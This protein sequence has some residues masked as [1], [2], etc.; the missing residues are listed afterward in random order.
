MSDKLI[1]EAEAKTEG[2]EPKSE[3]AEPKS[4]GAEP[5]SEG[6]EPKSEGAEPKSEGA[7]PKSE[8]AEPKRRRGHLRVAAILESAGA[9]FAQQ[10]YD[11]VTMTEVAV[12]SGTA[13]GSLYR[14]F[15]TKETLADALLKRYAERLDGA[16]AGLE[17]AARNMPL[18]AFADAL[19]EH[20]L[21]WGAQRAAALVLIE[22]RSVGGA[23]RGKLRAVL[24]D[25]L[26]EAV[27]AINPKLPADEV[28]TKAR[29]LQL[30]FKM[31]AGNAGEG[32]GV[33]SEIRALA[34][35]F[36]RERV[37]AG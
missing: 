5:K 19:V 7:E 2:A 22:A 26:A 3:G 36:L 27:A 20:A 21:A 10:G 8:G 29:V 30:I 33:L 16:L 4:E 34:R 14:F 13:I 31:A 15:P 24:H 11:A 25:R 17:R 35:L 6:A 23:Q 1:E 37:A 12:R 28:E 9:L 18:D 32:E